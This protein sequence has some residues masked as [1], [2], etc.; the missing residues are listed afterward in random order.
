[1]S[2]GKLLRRMAPLVRIIGSI[3]ETFILEVLLLLMSVSL[4]AL[5]RPWWEFPSPSQL[6]SSHS[7]TNEVREMSRSK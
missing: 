3:S 4:R 5:S 2:W 6:R 1:M 7:C